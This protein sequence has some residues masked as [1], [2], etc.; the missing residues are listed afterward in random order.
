MFAVSTYYP[1]SHYVFLLLPTSAALLHQISHH[2]FTKG[3]RDAITSGLMNAFCYKNMNVK[4]VR[5]VIIIILSLFITPVVFLCDECS[6][7]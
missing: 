1:S 2:L 5:S 6:V 4:C 7:P 3:Q